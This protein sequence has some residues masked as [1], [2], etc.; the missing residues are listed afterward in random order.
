LYPD[1]ISL[2]FLFFPPFF[3][4]WMLAGM[5]RGACIYREESHIFW[6]A[7]KRVFP[8]EN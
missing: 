3:L 1:W 7:P 8:L 6:W 4:I 5:L 2:F